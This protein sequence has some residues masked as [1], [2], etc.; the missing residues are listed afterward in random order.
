[1]RET[2]TA[3]TVGIREF[4]PVARIMPI[5]DL[6]HTRSVDEGSA[7]PRALHRLAGCAVVCCDPDSGVAYPD[8][9]NEKQASAKH[10][11]VREAVALAEAGHSLVLYHHFARRPHELQ[12]RELHH[13]LADRLAQARKALDRYLPPI[14]INAS[15]RLSMSRTV[16]HSNA[17]SSRRAASL[18]LP[19]V[20]HTTCGG[21]PN[22]STKATKSRSLVNIT[23]PAARAAS[24]MASS[25]MR[26]KPRSRTYT[27]S[28]DNVVAIHRASRGDR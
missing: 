18:V 24:K 27:V 4:G 17:R 22:R 11:L 25:G 21:G 3:E 5:E 20:S 9:A 23:A 14:S 28:T 2:G 8:S 6:P 15:P 7:L 19:Q 16:G 26:V 10:L 1:M 13:M 12:A